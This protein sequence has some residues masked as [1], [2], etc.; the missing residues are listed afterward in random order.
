MNALRLS[1]AALLVLC[2]ATLAQAQSAAPGDPLL[3]VLT[4]DYPPPEALIPPT[5]TRQAEYK[6]GAGKKI[7][8]VDFVENE[9]YVIHAE[10]PAIAYKAVK[11]KPLFEDDTLIAEQNSR[12]VALLDD[13]SSFTLGAQSKIRLDKSAYDAAK[14]LRDTSLDLLAGKARFVV[15]KMEQAGGDNF[16]VVTP[17]AT[18]GVRGSDFVVALTPEAVIP[19]RRTSLLDLLASPAH[20]ANGHG[21]IIVAGPN[22]TLNVQGMIGPPVI[23]TSFTVTSTLPGQPPQPPLT[24]TP[25]LTPG[26]FNR[27]APPVSVMSMPEVLE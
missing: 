4:K 27:F 1:L 8:L 24:V 20:A 6:D 17:V 11:S 13:Q 21:V 18:C 16:K 26:V 25:S 5:V 9:A 15:K 3:D 10:T 19:K 14:G 22:T 2:V 7:G 23:L 12:L